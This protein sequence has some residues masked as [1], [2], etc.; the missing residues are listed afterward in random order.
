MRHLPRWLPLAVLLS[1]AAGTLLLW[2]ALL[3]VQRRHAEQAVQAT[4]EAV[5][6]QFQAE[7]RARL[8]ALSRIAG[9]WEGEG[10]SSRRAW[11]TAAGLTL[12]DYPGIQSIQWADSTY[13]IRWIMPRRGFEAAQGIYIVTGPRRAAVLR[14]ARERRRVAVAPP[15]ELAVGGKGFVAFAPVF[16][17]GRFGGFIAGVFR[18]R[19]SLGVLLG[20]E[21]APGYGLSVSQGGEELYRRDVPG[22]A[23]PLR[24]AQARVE[25]GGAW[26]TV[27][28]WPGPAV[29]RETRSSLPGVV[30]GGGLLMAL[31]LGAAAHLLRLARLNAGAAEAARAELGRE[32]DFALQVMGTMGQGLT[33]VDAGGRIEYAN[34]AFGRMLGM[35][36]AELIGR[37]PWEFTHPDDIAELRRA[38][39]SRI[40]GETTSH[41][42][43]LL[44]PDGGV[45]H[46]LATGSPRAGGGAF[47]GA[48]T[49]VSNVTRQK[50]AERSLRESEERYRSLVEVA[51]D[52]IYRSDPQ[53]RFVYV[54]PVAERT[55]GR[56]ASELVGLHFLELV[57]PDAREATE[58][59]YQQQFRERLP[60]TYYE[61]PLLTA[62]GR[63]LW[64]GQNVHILMD[65]DWV[66]GFQAVARDITA[67]REVERLKDEFVSVAG[68]ELRTPLTS[69]RG[70]LQLLASGVLG[71]V[72]EK[73]VSILQIAVR[74][75]ERLVRLVSDLLDMERLASGKVA[76]DFCACSSGQLVQVAFESVQGMAE[77]AGVVLAD[78]THPARVW[79]DQ[80]RIVQVLVNLLSNAVKYSPEHG[81]VVVQAVEQAGELRFEVRDEGRG[82]PADKLEYVFG[83]FQQVDRADARIKGGSGLGLAIARSIVEQHGGRIGVESVYGKGSTF[84]F[85]VPLVAAPD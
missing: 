51:S 45:V 54:N 63:E 41:E 14:G 18:A 73:G 53:G 15:A 66:T 70:S 77:R 50:E 48:I 23:A 80:D 16:P 20:P 40:A 32:R 83:R 5:R 52:I 81:E 59:F 22:A 1:T 33:V 17:R 11:E 24:A 55:T 74:N 56:T 31:L 49:V 7:M 62:D 9:Q 78:Q 2:L 60:S 71:P 42:L 8:Q 27:A 6:N 43:R 61:F 82:I 72:S 75:T 19:E 13:S 79:V 30:L 29:M 46:T 38:R 64:V 37:T 84:W 28:V 85:S 57:H 68:H 76:L 12:R 69:I 35:D 39:S 3:G 4:A 67:R 26:W 65:G 25:L 21:I 36:P 44:R 58:R 10:G 47:R 34:P